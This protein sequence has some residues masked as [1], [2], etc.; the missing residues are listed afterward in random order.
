MGG[1]DLL[2]DLPIEVD[3]DTLWVPG[4]FPDSRINELEQP[5][6]DFSQ[7]RASLRLSAFT[8]AGPCRIFAGFPIKR[9][10]HQ[11]AFLTTPFYFAL[12][13]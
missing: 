12:S 13:S 6:Q 3:F 11:T 7:W 9:D 2:I 4:R 8:V 5:S 1:N 10:S